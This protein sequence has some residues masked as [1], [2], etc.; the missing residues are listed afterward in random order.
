MNKVKSERGYNE[1][2]F[3]VMDVRRMDYANESFDLVIDKST[4]D[5]LMCSDNPLM[6]VGRMVDEC[7][8]VLVPNGIYFVLSYAAPATR[9]EHITREH[10]SW[11]VEKKQ[12]SRLNE[13]GEQL[14]HFLYICKK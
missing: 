10:V 1:M 3:E 4:I 11:N 6:N 8:R 12:V 5:S 2:I 14:I 9:Y 13:E 7:Y